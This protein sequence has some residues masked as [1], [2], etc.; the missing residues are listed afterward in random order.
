MLTIIPIHFILQQEWWKILQRIF[1]RDFKLPKTFDY[2]A[3]I[4]GKLLEAMGHQL[5][6]SVATWGIVLGLVFTFCGVGYGWK[7]FFEAPDLDGS[8]SGLDGS[9]SGLRRMLEAAGDGGYTGDV[10]ADARRRL[11]GASLTPANAAAQFVFQL[12]LA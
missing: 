1:Q 12:T 2:T 5:H 3:Y 9:S 11:G 7:N 6:V 4:Q 8:A 10:G